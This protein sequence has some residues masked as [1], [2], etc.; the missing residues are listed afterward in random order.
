VVGEVLDLR[1]LVV[2]REQD[3]VL[4]LLQA[5]DLG[6]ELRGRGSWRDGAA[7]VAVV[8]VMLPED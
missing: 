4:L 8:R 1:V 6:L 5:Q 3:G 7:G 2:V